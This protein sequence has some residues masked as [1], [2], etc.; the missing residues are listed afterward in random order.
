MPVG[1]DVAEIAEA[2]LNVLFHTQGKYPV[3]SPANPNGGTPQVVDSIRPI[4]ASE[5]A[6]DSWASGAGDYTAKSY[7]STEAIVAPNLH[8][9][10]DAITGVDWDSTNTAT[11][12]NVAGIKTPILIMG[13]TASQDI[14][15]VQQEMYYQAAVG[16]SNKTLVYV[17]GATHGLTPCTTCAGA[18]GFGDTVAETFNYM[19]NWLTKN[20][21][22]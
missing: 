8:I 20:F 17:D 1:R 18:S 4:S 5:A 2:D 22:A 15:P 7:M 12:D 10:D 16:T 14:D 9:T 21:G 19:S 11:V 13:M 3:I 6:D